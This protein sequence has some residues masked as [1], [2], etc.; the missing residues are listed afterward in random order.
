M[1]SIAAA[2]FLHSKW[3]FSHIY[4]FICGLSAKKQSPIRAKALC[5]QIILQIQRL[6]QS[7]SFLVKCL[8]VPVVLNS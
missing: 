2:P 4:Y 1:Y 3:K 8:S 6:A 5:G 7:D